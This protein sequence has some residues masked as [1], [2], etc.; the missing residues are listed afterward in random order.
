M[1]RRA[2]LAA[3]LVIGIGVVVL[4]LFQLLAPPIAE[5]R[6][7]QRLE[8]SGRVERVEIS[9]FPAIELLWG[10]ADR[11]VVRM[12]DSRPGTGGLADLL[13]DTRATD[14][15][16][17]RV[18]DLRVLTLDLRDVRLRKRGPPL[19][20]AQ[21]AT[22]AARLPPALSPPMASFVAST[23]IAA[24]LAATHC[25]AATTSSKAPGKRASGARR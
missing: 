6:L 16:D 22:A 13:A 12:R 21:I 25:S 23:P 2:G 4:A 9:A 20:R 24:P 10:D 14:D 1:W 5:R 15:L 7:R 18:A 19:S 17:A 8:R 11:V 3:A